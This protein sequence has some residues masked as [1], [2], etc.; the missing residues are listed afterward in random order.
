M[1]M[2]FLYNMCI[3]GGGDR[4]KYRVVWEWRTIDPKYIPSLPEHY[5]PGDIENTCFNNCLK[6]GF[7]KK[8]RDS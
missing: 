6:N 1:E 3:D 2:E 7:F 8:I 4:A 5:T